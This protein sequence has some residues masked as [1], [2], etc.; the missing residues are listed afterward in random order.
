MGTVS[1]QAFFE[2]EVVYSV[3]EYT[4]SQIN[5]ES[6][7]PSPFSLGSYKYISVDQGM[8]QWLLWEYVATMGSL[9]LFSISSQTL[10]PHWMTFS[11]YTW[12]TSTFILFSLWILSLWAS[13]FQALIQVRISPSRLGLLDWHSYGP[14]LPYWPILQ[15][16]TFFYENLEKMSW[17]PQC[18]VHYL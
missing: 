5:S 8:S 10:W 16:A 9:Q 3:C 15:D 7:L 14:V 13:S 4:Y 17:T 11:F 1:I 6:D 2:A 18:H 12:S